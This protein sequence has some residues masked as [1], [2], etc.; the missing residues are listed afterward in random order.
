MRTITII[1]KMKKIYPIVYFLLLTNLLCAQSYEI[2]EV[3]ELRNDLTARIKN[4]EDSNGNV[5]AFVRV[6]IPSANGIHF[7]TSIVGEPDY[8]PGEYNVFIPEN[9][10]FLTFEANGKQYEIDFS[11]YDINIEGKKSYRV[12]LTKVTASTKPMSKVVITANYD[13]AVVMID[14]VPVGQTPLSID[15]VTSGLHTLSIPNTFGVTMEDTIINISGNKNI[16]L[17]LHKTK[18]KPVYVDMATPGGDTAGWYKVFGTNVKG[19]EGAKGMVDYAGNILVPYEYDYIYPGIQNGYYIVYK[20]DKAGLYDSEKGLVVPCIYDGFVTLKSYNH[21][22]YMPVDENNIWGVLSPTGKLVIPLEYKNYPL[23][24]ENAIRVEKKG[25]GYGLFA[26]NGQAIVSPKYKYLHE[27]INGYAFWRKNDD[28]QGFVDINGNE[29]TIPSNYSKGFDAIMSSGLFGVKDKETEK[30]GFMDEQMNLIIPTEYDATNMYNVPYFNQ[31]I[32]LL[33][34]NDDEVVLN[35]K[36]EVVLSKNEQRLNNIEIVCQSKRSGNRG[37]F[38]TYRDSEGIIDNTFIKVENKEGHCGLFDVKGNVIV[39][40]DYSE[41]GIQWFTDN[42]TNY[43]V[44]RNNNSLDVINEQ[45]QILFSL[46]LSMEIED[47]SDGFVMIKD[48]ETQSYGYLNMK[49]E[50]LANCIY[51]YYLGEEEMDEKDDEEEKHDEG[52][53]ITEIIDDWPIS[54][55]LA[56]LSVGDRF[57]F[58]DNAGTIKVPLKYTAVTPFENGIAYVRDLNGKWEKI[59]KKDL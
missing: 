30:W 52:Y 31:G 2:R 26:Y 43:F 3:V 13:N 48:L 6:N 11:K 22:A 50:V 49:G 27:F 25:S 15:N 57:G 58:I 33:K 4:I 17:T 20:D 24:C 19:E 32:V 47:I 54:E 35:S 59:Y 44:L 53:N 8:L 18:R 36:G 14:G 38:F 28:S 10:R 37:R 41:L 12:V 34:L 46:P 23:C 7:D 1:I 56:I 40:C 9:T 16:S 21:D 45:R 51:G 5:C 39:P 42:N 55:G 29:R